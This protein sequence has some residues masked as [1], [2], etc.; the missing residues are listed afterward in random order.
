MSILTKFR[1][2]KMKVIYKRNQDRDKELN[3][4]ALDE[5]GLMIYDES[6]EDTHILNETA[7]Y[8]FELLEKPMT[9]KEIEEIFKEKYK[10]EDDDLETLC[11]DLD[12][13]LEEMVEKNIIS[14]E[15]I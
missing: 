8:I 10:F 14:S 5:E 4:F 9:L 11:D 13:I 6:S 7:Q 15:R 12:E 2:I 1:R 3:T